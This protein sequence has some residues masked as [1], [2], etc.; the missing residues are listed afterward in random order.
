MKDRWLS[1]ASPLLLI[2]IWELLVNVGIL[3]RL[4]FPAPSTVANTF[5]KLLQEGELAHHTSITVARVLV[6]FFAGAVPAIA[7]G[8]LMGIWRP[9]RLAFEPLAAAIYPIPKIALVPLFIV[10]FGIGETSKVV[11]IAFS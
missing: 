6:G 11:I 8:M 3:N 7:L 9:A 2:L 1:I 10:I 4:F 5:W